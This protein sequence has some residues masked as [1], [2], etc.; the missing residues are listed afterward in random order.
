[1]IKLKYLHDSIVYKCFSMFEG[2]N[3]FEIETDLI[4]DGL[5]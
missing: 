4:Y 5:H 1:M 3:V 2:E